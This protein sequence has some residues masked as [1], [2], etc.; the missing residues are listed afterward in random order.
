M[1]SVLTDRL[2]HALTLRL[3]VWYF[4][5][6]CASSTAV[7]VLVYALVA[8][9]LRQRDHDA[10]QDL[11]ARY[12]AA[13]RRGGIAAIDRIVA[14]DRL[15]GRYEPFFLRV[16]SGP[17]AVLYLTLP[18]DWRTLDI[19]RLDTLAISPRDSVE[20][21][22]NG[23]APLDVLSA[24]LADGTTLQLGKSSA[25]RVDALSRFRARALLIVGVVFAAALIGGVLLTY[26]GLAPLR[27][28]TSTIRRILQTGDLRTRVP[29]ERTTDPLGEV[30]VLFN[31]LL[32][33]LQALIGGMRDAL[34]T[35]AHD[36]RTPMTRIRSHA[37]S[38]LAGPRNLDRFEAALEET[39]EEIDR[40]SQMLATI[41]D[42]SEAQTG[43]MRLNRTMVA[44]E[45]IFEETLELYGDVAEARQV[46]LTAAA[47][48][49]L[50]ANVDHNR[51]RQ[52]MA[53]LVDNAIK[54]TPEGGRVHLDANQAGGWVELRV[55]DTGVGIP[56]EE[57]PRIWD[58]LFR[59][60]RSRAERGLGLGLS[61]VKAVVEAHG[62]RALVSSAPA[63]GSVFT[64][65]IP[66][67]ALG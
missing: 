23:Q 2:R 49:G 67:G 65:T 7:L 50:V 29:V 43:A 61:L 48:A 53:N 1:S 57:L 36:L 40:V 21:P 35:V 15:S 17:N 19:S 60:E 34:D 18:A 39:L 59:G 33:R 52:V 46:S 58:R 30:A 26:S 4:V 11:V 38:A 64:V 8:A 22:L 13:Y 3:A 31:D 14:D 47:P 5:I 45:A 25:L 20:M 42:I 41:M 28:L 32:G 12:A 6:F 62:G 51:I 66:A 27:A 54:H 63:G 24:R 44:V 10:L 37:E 16:S 56:A 55:T 9:S